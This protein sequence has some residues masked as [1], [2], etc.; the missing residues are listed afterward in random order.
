MYWKTNLVHGDLSV[1]SAATWRN[2]ATESHR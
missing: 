2:L 1:L